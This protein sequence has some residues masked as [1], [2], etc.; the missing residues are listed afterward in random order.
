M[1]QGYK[2]K[3]DIFEG[4]LDLLLH[5]I[6]QYEIDIYDIP[7]TEITHQYMQFINQMK[8]IQL[9]IAS[10]YL[11]MAATL[12]SIKSKMLLPKKEID[13]DDD[14]TEDP[15]EELIERLIEYR[16]YKEIANQ[17]KDKE[18]KE[19]TVYTRAP[20]DFKNILDAPQI[21][22]GNVSI[23]EMLSA[24]ETVFLRKEWNEPLDTRINRSEIT[25]EESMSHIKE[26]IKYRQKRVSFS[27]L[28]QIPEKLHIITTFLAI[29]E[30][31]KQNQVECKQDEQFSDIYI[32]LLEG[33]VDH[34]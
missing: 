24:L 19:A 18:L 28:F 31:M 20:I 5:L 21:T 27:E 6:K 22:K 7:M 16:K 8:N 10:E 3:T 15:R 13:S 11:V 32:S 9:D 30:L 34:E 2:V 26:Y 29:L 1:N 14:Y 17:L 23:Y 33:K 12:L 25:V 4:P